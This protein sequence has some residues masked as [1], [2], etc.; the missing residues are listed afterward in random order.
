MFYHLDSQNVI[1]N[2]IIWS[3]LSQFGS[4]KEEKKDFPKDSFNDL[5]EGITQLV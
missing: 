2:A 5:L 3:Q 4:K 1:K